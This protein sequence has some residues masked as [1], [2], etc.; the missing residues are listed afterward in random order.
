LDERPI[1][2][3]AA[4]G[5]ALNLSLLAF[6]MAGGLAYGTVVWLPPWR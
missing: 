3:L 6:V 5:G 4:L 2:G 1:E